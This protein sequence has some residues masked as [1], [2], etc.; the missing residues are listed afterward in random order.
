MNIQRGA[1]RDPIRPT[2]I[3]AERTTLRLLGAILLRGRLIGDR[4]A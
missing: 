4:R 1:R 2:T 3:S